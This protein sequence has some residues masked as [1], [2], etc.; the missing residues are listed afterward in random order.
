MKQEILQANSV[1]EINK[2]LEDWAGAYDLD[3]AA[4]GEAGLGCGVKKSLV[5][6]PVGGRVIIEDTGRDVYSIESSKS[7]QD[8][9][10]IVLKALSLR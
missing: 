10:D 8:T 3:L 2:I 6:T 4:V 7:L 1:F 9:K 5:K